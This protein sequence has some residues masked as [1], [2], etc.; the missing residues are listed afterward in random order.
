[1]KKNKFIQFLCTTLFTLS[2]YTSSHAGNTIVIDDLRNLNINKNTVLKID[3]RTVPKIQGAEQYGTGFL[4]QTLPGFKAN[5]NYSAG[6]NQNDGE[7]AEI[8]LINSVIGPVTANNTSSFQVLLVDLVVDADTLIHGAANIEDITLGSIVAASGVESDTGVIRATRIEVLHNGSPYWLMTG[9]VLNLNESGFNI[10]T[11]HLNFTST[12]GN[13]ICEAGT[14]E[15]GEKI[16]AEI[17]SV[18]DYSIGDAVDAVTVTCYDDFIFPSDPPA[19]VFING[20]IESVNAN[21][22]NIVVDGTSVTINEHTEIFSNTGNTILEA[23]MNVSVNGYEDLDTNEIIA[24]FIFINDEPAIP[25][26]QPL[27]IY[28]ALT[29]VTAVD[30]ELDGMV[31]SYNEDTLFVAGTVANLVDGAW[32]EVIVQRSNQSTDVLTAM[33]ISFVPELPPGQNIVSVAGA[34]SNLS[35][36]HLNFSIGN[37]TIEL[38]VQLLRS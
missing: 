12:Q 26:N 1:M 29:N 31:V 14:F 4:S 17:L 9:S 24:Y 6:A 18:V 22:T 2:I 19:S 7:L 8:N 15:N 3:G 21:Q 13:V 10:G 5:V 25:P 34:I 11:Q 27:V 32:I 38:S 23:G 30:F 16:I 20:L 36:D 28:G 35:A 33:Q 37:E